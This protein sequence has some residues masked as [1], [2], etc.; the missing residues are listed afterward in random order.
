MKKIVL[1]LFIVILSHAISAFPIYGNII[2]NE[3]CSSM[4]QLIKVSNEANATHLLICGDNNVA[5]EITADLLQWITFVKNESM[6][7]FHSDSLA[8]V[9]SINNIK[10]IAVKNNSV[11]F[12]LSIINNIV[13]KDFI[14][15][16]D[17]IIR[18]SKLLGIQEKNLHKAKKYQIDDQ[19]PLLNEIIQALHERIMTVD[20][21]GSELKHQLPPKLSF[22]MNRF[23][24]DQQSIVL[25]WYNYPEIGLKDIY[26]K[27]VQS[28]QNKKTLALFVDGLGYHNLLNYYARKNI[29]QPLLNFSPTRSVLPS[30]TKYASYMLGTGSYYSPLKS[31]SI[32]KDPLFKDGVIIEE[33]KVYHQSKIETILNT[34]ENE[35]GTIDDEIFKDLKKQMKNDRPFIM[36]HFHSIDDFSHNYGPFHPM[37]LERIDIIMDY[38][39]YCKKHFDGNI[40]IYSDHGQHNVPNIGGNHGSQRAQDMIGVFSYV[41]KN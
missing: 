41:E 13:Q 36:A 10:Y 33:E 26:E 22:E 3:N 30:V 15:P 27:Q 40:I 16:Y 21:L 23:A 18:N 31:D 1:I 24:L 7:S 29:S 5:V 9:C 17:F 4:D 38:I 28:V 35:N 6:I 20:H 32:Y 19:W 39:I 37:T 8:P 25:L 34:D 14:S 12:S 2:Y 11:D